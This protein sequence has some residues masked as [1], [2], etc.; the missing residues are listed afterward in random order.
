MT[1]LMAGDRSHAW[2]SADGDGAQRWLLIHSE[3]R[4][5]QAQRAV[6]TPL[7]THSDREGKAF[8]TRCGPTCACEADAQQA[9]STFAQGVQATVLEQRTIRPTP[10]DGQR[11][12]PGQSPLPAHIVYAI[13]RALASR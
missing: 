5:P 8:K 13:D 4:P 2:A 9:L 11:G 3:A 10:H 6:N 1:P 7:L 12:R